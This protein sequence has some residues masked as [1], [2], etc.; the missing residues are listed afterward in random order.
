MKIRFVSKVTLFQQALE[1]RVVIHVCY[2][3]Q[4]LALQGKIPTT[5][6]WAIAKLITSTL[7]PVVSSCVFNQCCGS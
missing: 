3:Q 6:V 1:F 5:Q 2:N 7:A 4:T